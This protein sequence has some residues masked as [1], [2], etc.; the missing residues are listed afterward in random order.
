[1]SR[2]GGPTCS[3]TRQSPSK[4]QLTAT[5]QEALVKKIRDAG[6]S[7]YLDGMPSTAESEVQEVPTVPESSI[8][9]SYESRG[10]GLIQECQRA[11]THLKESQ[12]YLN[13][14]TEEGAELA[15]DVEALLQKKKD[16]KRREREAWAELQTSN[17][18]D[19]VRTVVDLLAKFVSDTP[20]RTW[21]S[22]T[23]NCVLASLA[24]PDS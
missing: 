4:F 11:E 23:T 24:F 2:K 6:Y 21:T 14:S 19:E 16:L 3:R 10:A 5:Q 18:E 22:G 17:T 8:L 9:R 13:E 20:F 15:L 7:E 12:R 1:M